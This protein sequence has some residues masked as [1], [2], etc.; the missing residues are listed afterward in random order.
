MDL[1]SRTA[2]ARS[3]GSGDLSLVC[4]DLRQRHVKAGYYVARCGEPVEHWAGVIDG[5]VHLSVGCAEGRMSALIHVDK[6]EWFD[7]S[8]L[9]RA[10]LRPYD[11]VA[12]RDTRLLL[13]PAYVF[14]HLAATNRSFNEHI[15]QLIA[16]R[17]DALIETL[18]GDRLYDS[19]RRVAQCLSRLSRDDRRSGATGFLRL[20]QGEIGLL[21]GVSRQRTNA[22]LRRLAALDIVKLRTRGVSILD[23]DALGAFGGGAHR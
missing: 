19:Q 7:E 14:R 2:W 12:V 17:M 10:R 13:M 4:G 1:L 9:L 21:S 15:L 23:P 5:L 22:A 3:L 8:S 6:G 18:E 11:A 16:M 20:T